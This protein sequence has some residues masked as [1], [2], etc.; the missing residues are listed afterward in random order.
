MRALLMVLAVVI[1]SP[2]P[3]QI[4]TDGDTIKLAGTTYRLWGI[5]AAEAH[6]ACS[7][8]WVAGKAATEYLTG[9][10]RGKSVTCEAKVI[11]RYG[12]T[13]A[14]CRAN[15]RDLGAD[16][17]AAGMAWAFTRYSMDYVPQEAAARLR[18]LGVHGHDGCEKPWDWRAQN[19]IKR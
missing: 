11:D 15:G 3:A 10:M 7:D 5:D 19:R 13:V 14:I 18:R 12:R 4:I 17:V 8:G 1:A 6:Q 9:M 2:A 16:M